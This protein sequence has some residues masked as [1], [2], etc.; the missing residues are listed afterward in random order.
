LSGQLRLLVQVE[1]VVDVARSRESRMA[2][3]AGAANAAAVGDRAPP[4]STA[5]C[6]KLQLVDGYSYG[7]RD[8]DA[9]SRPRQHSYL[10][11]MELSAIP[12]L[13]ETTPAGTKLLLCL[14][15]ADSGG[16]GGL[17]TEE[18]PQVLRHASRGVLLLTPENCLV[19]GGHVSELA[20]VQA[21]QRHEARERSGVGTD[22]TV[23]AL[24]SQNYFAREEDD[25]DDENHGTCS[26]RTRGTPALI[27]E[28]MVFFSFA[29]L[30]PWTWNRRARGREPRR[31]GGR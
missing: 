28:L 13:S 18:A 29:M 25:D 11:A 30:S 4:P 14:A 19:V 17:E 15:T 2:V 20:S 16:A 31:D 6:L 26:A 23:R 8:A 7:D 10:V 21:S 22:P 12:N 5:R 1:D 3:T 9:S 24:I 27:K